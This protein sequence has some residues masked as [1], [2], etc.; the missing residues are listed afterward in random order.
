MINENNFITLA[1]TYV[2]YARLGLV[3][4]LVKGSDTPENIIRHY[5]SELLKYGIAAAALSDC[6]LLL[7]FEHRFFKDGICQN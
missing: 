7:Y 3:L 1:V 4:R 5:G 2:G 6:R